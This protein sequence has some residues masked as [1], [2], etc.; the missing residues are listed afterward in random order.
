[1]ELYTQAQD[2]F[3]KVL[4]AVPAAGWSRPS[5]CR[6]WTVRD[7]AGHAIWGQLQLHAWATGGP[8]PA[9]DGAPG[10]PAPAVMTGDDPL[11]TWRAARTVPAPTQ[12]SRTVAITG[13]GEVPVAALLSLLVTDLT[14]HTWDIGRA[15]GLPVDLPRGLVT[16]SFGWAREHVVRRPGFFGPELTPAADA[17][18]QTRML[19]FLGRAT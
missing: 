11:A 8:D 7:V 2:E 9:R 19:A 18:A 10:M 14:A 16:A 5:M 4:A 3:D 1:M 15:L 17:D 12:L 13:M 6:D